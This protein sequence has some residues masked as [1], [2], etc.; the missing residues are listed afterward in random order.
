QTY[1]VVRKDDSVVEG[2]F[3]GIDERAITLTFMGGATLRVPLNTIAKAGYVAGKS[4]MPDGLDTDLSAADFRDLIAYLRAE[5]VPPSMEKIEFESLGKPEVRNG[6]PAH[7]QKPGGR[8]DP[9]TLSGEHHYFMP[10][11]KVGQSVRFTVPATGSSPRRIRLGLTT[12]LD[13]GVFDILVNDKPVKQKVD[14]YSADLAV[15]EI[16]LGSHIPQKGTLAIELKLAAAN[17][18]GVGKRSFG[19]LD[20]LLL[21]SRT[22]LANVAADYRDSLPTRAAGG[23][24]HYQS[25]TD[26]NPLN[27][28]LVPLTNATLG[29]EHASGYGGTGVVFERPS[30]GPFP[31]VS[32]QGLF[33]RVKM[34]PAG[35]LAVHPGQA[36]GGPPEYLVVEYRAAS[37]QGKLTL[38]YSINN[39]LAAGDGIDWRLLDSAGKQLFGGALNGKRAK[40]DAVSIPDLEAGKSLW[41]VIGN[42][43]SDNPGADQTFVSLELIGTGAVRAGAPAANPTPA[44]AP[45]PPPPPAK[46]VAKDLP[47]TSVRFRKQQLYEHYLSEGASAGDIDGDGKTDIVAGAAWW[48]GPLFQKAFAYEPIKNFPITGP[49]LSGYSTN[50]FTF[51]DELTG[52]AWAEIIK[53]SIPGRP[54]QVALNPGQHP[55]SFE[56][57]KTAVPSAAGPPHICNE[58]PQYL[59]V[60]GDAR[61]ELLAFSGNQIVLFAATS[62]AKPTW[63]ALPITPKSGRFPVY[64]HGLG[65]GDIDGD[66]LQDILEKQGWWQQP[67]DWDRKAPWTFHAYAFG[68]KQGG[69][70]MFAY[71]VDGDGLSDVVTAL[72]AHSYGFAW[73]QQK[74]QGERIDFIRHDIM[75]DKP[76]DNPYGVCFSQPHAIDCADIDGDGIKDIITGKCYFAHNGRDPGAKDPAVLYWFRTTRHPDGTAELIPYL[77]DDNSGVGRQL[78]VTDVNADGKP[79]VVTSNKKGVFAFI[80][81]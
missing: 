73:Y 18:R 71:D 37:A 6:A 63:E 60:I 78:T 40:G 39:A 4:V 59:D 52:D 28:G 9:R 64:L 75:T 13:F 22:V 66:G 26:A 41:L 55:K 20:Y 79:D 51:P 21:E 47:P 5:P 56:E 15:Q 57:C 53:V 67:A 3:S 11:N 42:G 62:A 72:N 25:D 54:A 65:A 48:Q 32:N 36:T 44:P 61:K 38:S 45:V 8:F 35:S 46:V 14:A 43:P 29:T 17:S 10:F 34:P 50:F 70:Q 68:P 2:Y 31:M 49:G 7:V 27:G 19:G 76:A 58:S 69:A 80:Q 16:D 77:I 1:R 23:S 33:D 74:R 12:C 81:E 30:L 24:W